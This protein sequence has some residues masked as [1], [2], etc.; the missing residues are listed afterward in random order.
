MSKSSSPRGVF[1]TWTKWAKPQAERA[2]GPVGQGLRWFGLRL[3]CHILHEEEMPE[4]VEKVGGGRSTWPTAQV[5]W[6]TGHHLLPN[7]PLQV[8]GVP[9]HSYKYPPRGESGHT[10]HYM[11]IPLA[12]LSLPV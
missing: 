1:D 7:R 10:H 12:K 8:G 2:Q 9:I 5:A 11:E 4:S 3:G 6:P